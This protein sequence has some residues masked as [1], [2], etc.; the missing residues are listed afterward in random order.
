MISPYFSP[1][2]SGIIFKNCLNLDITG[3]Y[4]PSSQKIFPKKLSRKEQF[5]MLKT[6]LS[7][8]RTVLGQIIARLL[9]P[10]SVCL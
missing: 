10:A 4:Q 3:E 6:I 5:S 7:L 9:S 8:I 1:L 2:E